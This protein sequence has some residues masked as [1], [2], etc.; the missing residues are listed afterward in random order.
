M[1][2]LMASLFAS[3]LLFGGLAGTASAQVEQDGLVNVNIGDVTIL[4]DVDVAV[5]ANLVAAVCLQDVNV[6]L[7]GAIEADESGTEYVCRA[8]GGR[9]QE[10]SITQN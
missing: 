7:L 3:A 6:V 5:A 10:I 8:G 1:R 2:K 4:E 9:G